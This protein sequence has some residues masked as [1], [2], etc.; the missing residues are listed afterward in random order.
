MFTIHS[1]RRIDTH[2]KYVVSVI[3]TSKPDCMK[4]RVKE[5]T[6]KHLDEAVQVIN[7]AKDKYLVKDGYAL[8]VEILTYVH[9]VPVRV[10]AFWVDKD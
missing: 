9:T 4:H 3:N 8:F 6:A 10:E 5:L 1:H 7:N 2:L